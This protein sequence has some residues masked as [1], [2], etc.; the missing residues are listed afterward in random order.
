MKKKIISIVLILVLLLLPFGVLLNVKATGVTFSL[1]NNT[2]N[3]QGKKVLNQVTNGVRVNNVGENDVLAMY[4]IV[5]LYYDTTSNQIS[6]GFAGSFGTYANAQN[7][8]LT[9]NDY[10]TTDTTDTTENHDNKYPDNSDFNALVSDY[11]NYVRTNNVS[12]TYSM[13]TSLHTAN[14]EY[15]YY[16]SRTNVEA[17]IYLVLPSSNPF[18][19][20]N[21]DGLMLNNMSVYS[22]L[23]A[24]VVPSVSNGEWVF[25]DVEIDAKK[26][27]TIAVN[28]LADTNVAGFVS[29]VGG[30]QVSVDTG[31]SLNY[32]AGKNYMGVAINYPVVLPGN[33][34]SSIQ[35]LMSNYTLNMFDIIYPAAVVPNLSNVKFFVLEDVWDSRISNNKYYVT[36]DA[37]GNPLELEYADVT[38]S[39]GKISF[40]YDNNYL[41]G[42]FSIVYNLDI[43]AASLSNAAAGNT[44]TTISYS[45]KDPYVDIGSNVTKSDIRAAFDSNDANYNSNKSVNIRKAIAQVEYTSTLYATGVTVNNTNSSNNA[46]SGGEFAVYGSYSNGTY[47]NQL[48]SNIVMTNGTGSL[49]GLDP[50]Q[51]YYL[52][53]VKAPTGYRL[54]DDKIIVLPG[55]NDNT[56]YDSS[57]YQVVSV[58]NGMYTANIVN[59]PMLALPFTGG[60]GTVIYTVIGLIIVV[61]AGI[62]LVL[63]KKK[64]KNDNKESKKE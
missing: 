21:S 24:N 40:D 37:D 16:A 38:T 28:Q 59:S 47:S 25:E 54:Y 46:L 33:A 45:I 19:T 52:K 36:V 4:K 11:A 7:P 34:H 41:N 60:S 55:S 27:A 20:I 15:Y 64:N 43:D 57:T 49:N 32:I 63:Y 10:L 14:N 9:V 26:E 50:T 2:T 5:D 62:F 12:A 42:F 35:D 17:G 29:R 23:I 6:Y 30:A 3:G 13:T 8:A 1:D 39:T 51:T 58:S 44:I 18:S 61:G 22:V 31:T 56:Q 48:G 53:Q